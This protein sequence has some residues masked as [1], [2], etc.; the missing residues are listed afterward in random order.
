MPVWH[1]TWPAPLADGY[2]LELLDPVLRSPMDAGPPKARRRTIWQGPRVSASWQMTDA[3]YEVFDAWWSQ[4]LAQGALP[5]VWYEPLRGRPGRWMFAEAPALVETGPG[6]VR[7]QARLVCLEEWWPGV[8]A[9]QGRTVHVWDAHWRPS[10]F[11]DVDGRRAASLFG[12]IGRWVDRVGGGVLQAP[13]AEPLRYPEY[14]V[15]DA[16]PPHLWTDGEARMEMPAIALDLREFAVVVGCSLDPTSSLFAR[17]VSFA[18]TS[19]NDWDQPTAFIVSSY[20]H[21]DITGLGGG[22]GLSYDTDATLTRI[23]F[24]F[25]GGG[26]NGELRIDDVVRGMQG[27]VTSAQVTTGSLFLACGMTGG[28]ISNYGKRRIFGLATVSG[29]CPD[30]AER[31]ML[32]RWSMA[33]MGK[34]PYG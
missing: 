15:D 6:R 17:T 19:G 28:G 5:F 25:T 27:G 31:T 11:A 13:A 18:P 14:L 12:P 23:A 24:L 3:E 10:L 16:N 2:Q 4:D 34:D 33:L 29:Y 21:T 20:D 32:S 7:V 9:K 8:L 30:A 26:G 22:Y 1:H